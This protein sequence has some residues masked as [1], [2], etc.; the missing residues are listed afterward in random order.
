ML[1]KSATG[2]VFATTCFSVLAAMPANAARANWS[3]QQNVVQSNH[4]E[5]ML[6]TNR[7]F[8]E[9]RM[10]KECGPIT[11]PE[12]HQSC[13]ASFAQDEPASLTH[14]TK[15]PATKRHPAHYAGSSTPPQK[16]QTQS[17]R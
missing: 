12:L 3:P 10:R 1:L 5:R 7:S 11:D 13:I 14:R 16:H 2:L 15:G 8:R 6:E 9:A 4:Y 17:G